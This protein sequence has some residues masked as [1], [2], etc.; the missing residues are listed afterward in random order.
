M[1][2]ARNDG[3]AK[4]ALAAFAACALVSPGVL[5]EAQGA[6]GDADALAKQLSNPVASLISVPL[7]LNW[8]D[9]LGTG[10][11]GERWLLNVQPV[12]PISLNDDWN[13]ISRTILPVIHQDVTPGSSESGIGDVTQSLFFSPKHP[14]SS[15]WIWGVGPAFLLPTA[16]EEVL[17]T[18]QWA[19]GPT[20]V[21]LKQTQGGWTY[22]ALVNYLV[23]VAGD[24]DR[25][26]VNSM[27]LQPFLAKAL[28]KGRTLTANFESTY[29]FDAEQ[30][31]APFNLTF[32]EVTKIGNQRLSFAFGARYYLE[33]PDGGADWG[34]RFVVTLLYPK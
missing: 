12:V 8:D 9:G 5:A 33:T 13:I 30:W 16:S 25:A 32:S 34:L 23:S 21:A 6:G 14:T 28:G 1:R 22:G 7:Q 17:G 11:D 29:D 10:G 24:D 4:A 18:E 15:G 19:L 31:N 27:F 3:A 20:A 26:D 2:I